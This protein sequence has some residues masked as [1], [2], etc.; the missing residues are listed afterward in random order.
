MRDRVIKPVL[1]D[2]NYGPL[3]RMLL[4]MEVTGEMIA[5][6]RELITGK[7]REE[8]GLERVLDNLTLGGGWGIVADVLQATDFQGGLSSYA[9]GP[10]VSEVLKGGEN[11]RA[12]VEGSPG[13][14][15][16]QIVS[17]TVP[18]VAAIPVPWY[19]RPAVG[20]IP[21]ASRRLTQVMKEN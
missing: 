13:P 10:M 6:L 8:E 21:A 16:R 19:L 3:A 11:V 4:G 5:Q 12:A 7:E 14:L 18:F 17:G 20:A 1:E 9:L 2:G 15:Q